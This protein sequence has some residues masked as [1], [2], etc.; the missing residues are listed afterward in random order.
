MIEIN[1]SVCGICWRFDIKRCNRTFAARRFDG[2]FHRPIAAL[3]KKADRGHT[4]LR[5]DLLQ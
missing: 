2:F 1:H 4:E 3:A 5:Q